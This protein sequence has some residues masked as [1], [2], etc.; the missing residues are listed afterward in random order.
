MLGLQY[1][2]PGGI[3]AL[4]GKWDVL[5]PGQADDASDTWTGNGGAALKEA[6]VGNTVTYGE[7]EHTISD[8]PDDNTIVL[9]SPWG[10]PSGKG[11][12]VYLS[13]LLPQDAGG[14]PE[15]DAAGKPKAS[16]VSSSGAATP[17]WKNP[18]II[19]AI[20]AVAGLATYLILIRKKK[21]R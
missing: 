18:I 4:T 5:G 6:R 19:V 8:V 16:L 17:I 11:V 10:G 1:T 2:Q 15:L 9:T 3:R 13:G 7:S 20:L 21:K 14:P 12:Q